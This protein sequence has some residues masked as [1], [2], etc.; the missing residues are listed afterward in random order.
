MS[1][2]QGTD[3]TRRAK[4][5]PETQR[6]R[7]SVVPDS[8]SLLSILSSAVIVLAA[9][10]CGETRMSAG[11]LYHDLGAQALPTDHLSSELSVAGT[12]SAIPTTLV[13]PGA[14][15]RVTVAFSDSKSFTYHTDGSPT[16][17]HFFTRTVNAPSLSFTI[18]RT[19]SQAATAFHA[20]QAGA[21]GATRF[22]GAVSQ[23]QTPHFCAYGANL[24]SGGG[25]VCVWVQG[26]VV[27]L[28]ISANSYATQAFQAQS[29]DFQSDVSAV[30]QAALS[31]LK[32]FSNG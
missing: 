16:S 15:G 12:N 26:R 19:A 17:D 11:Q 30:A 20:I 4:A 3:P 10:A 18:Y 27:A 2:P 9:S 1:V 21:T 28:A 32:S 7:R 6:H 13:W 29:R 23:A 22:K 14:I 24:T 25:A 31:D 5:R 8:Q